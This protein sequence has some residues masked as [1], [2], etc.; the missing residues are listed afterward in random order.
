MFEC[1]PVV[2]F[3]TR[4]GRT[5]RLVGMLARPEVAKNGRVR[6]ETHRR[7]GACSPSA[8]S[9][10]VVHDDSTAVVV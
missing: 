4:L 8:S 1:A 7:A 9:S 10:L 2:R 5:R 6:A 3:K